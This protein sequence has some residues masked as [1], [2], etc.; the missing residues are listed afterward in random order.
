[1]KTVN[2]CGKARVVA[3]AGPA[4]LNGDAYGF[5]PSMLIAL[6]GGMRFQSFTYPTLRACQPAV[7]DQDHCHEQ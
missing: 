3:G 5:V 1:M 6:C 2:D 7:R 4:S